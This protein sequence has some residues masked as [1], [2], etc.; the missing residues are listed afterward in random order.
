M[1]PQHASTWELQLH[2][3]VDTRHLHIVYPDTMGMYSI[4]VLASATFTRLN[5]R[6]CVCR[7]GGSQVPLTPSHMDLDTVNN[8]QYTFVT[9]IHIL[10]FISTMPVSIPSEIWRDCT[11]QMNE[12]VTDVKKPYA[13]L[14]LHA[15]HPWDVTCPFKD[16]QS[17]DV[18]MASPS[19]TVCR[20]NCPWE[21]ALL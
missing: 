16:N 18:Y 13:S 4:G 14:V 10:N 20:R 2:P 3:V 19:T 17:A 21:V 1:A 12:H 7:L 8:I 5:V 9:D 6:H 15:H 11:P